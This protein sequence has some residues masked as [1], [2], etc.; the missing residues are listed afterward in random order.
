[1][2][3]PLFALT[4]LA[5]VPTFA[6]GVLAG[7]R[8]SDP[9]ATSTACGPTQSVASHVGP[10]AK[11]LGRFDGPMSGVCRFACATK[12][13]FDAKDVLAQPGARADK[14]TQCPVSGVVFRV[15]AHR[16]HVRSGK[17]DYV[18]C[19]EKCAAKLKKDP[20]RYVRA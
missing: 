2:R 11:I 3:L 19:C 13:K 14:L 1:M 5:L 17:D 8:C 12:I 16:P 6:F 9:S 10:K 15:D 4:A 7:E 18:T 20:R